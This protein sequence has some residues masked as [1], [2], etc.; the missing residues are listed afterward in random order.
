M[1][2]ETVLTSALCIAL[3]AAYPFPKFPNTKRFFRSDDGPDDQPAKRALGEVVST[4]VA[5]LGV[6]DADGIGQGKDAYTQYMG[7]GST[8]AGWPAMSE[9]YDLSFLT[10]GQIANSA[11]R[12][13]FD[14]MFV[15]EDIQKPA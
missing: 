6:L 13:S 7:D 14:Y 3:A 1:R 5:A 12:V 9:W 10:D 2:F 4:A 11:F 8:A 15:T